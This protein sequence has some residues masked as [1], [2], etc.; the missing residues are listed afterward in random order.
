MVTSRFDCQKA[1]LSLLF[2][3]NDAI[4][5]PIKAKAASTRLSSLSQMRGGLSFRVA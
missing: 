3:M 1:R 2:A 4:T 5:E